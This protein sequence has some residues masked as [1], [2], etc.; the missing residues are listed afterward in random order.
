MQPI[1]ASRLRF[2][3]YAKDSVRRKSLTFYLL[4]LLQCILHV[5]R[6]RAKIRFM[7]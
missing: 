2:S 3:L 4:S 5:L 7:G 1:L 6:V